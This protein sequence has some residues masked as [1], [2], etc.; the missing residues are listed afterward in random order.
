MPLPMTR[1]CALLRSVNLGP[2]R[3]L[4]MDALRA[5]ASS[6]L[7][8]DVSSVAHT[9]NLVFDS[10]AQPAELERRLEAAIERDFGFTSLVFVRSA[11]H[12]AALVEHNPFPDQARD[13]PAHL[14]AMLMRQAVPAE[15]LAALQASIPGR[16]QASARGSDLYLCY[17]DGI[18]TSKFASGVIERRLGQPGTVR[19]WNTVLKVAAALG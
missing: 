14:V 5:A 6:V 3:R 9:G 15:R 11:A 13:D 18:G 16:E 19:N 8:A 10:R 4:K 17:P 1:Y 2:S 12:M 7:A